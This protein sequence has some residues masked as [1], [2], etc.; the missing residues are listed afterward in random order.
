MKNLAKQIFRQRLTI[1]GKYSIRI[2]EAVIKKYMLDLAKAI[3]MHSLMKPITF[4]PNERKHPLHHGIAGFVGWVESG[5]SVYTWDKFN[6]FTVEIYTCK[7]FS[8]EKV[9]K[10]TKGFFESKQIV[11]ESK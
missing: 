5:C 1:E 4:K 2:S 3:G 8:V 9:V 6:F 10:F 7:K 11:F